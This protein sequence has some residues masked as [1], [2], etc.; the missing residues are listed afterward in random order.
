M[1]HTL[2]HGFFYCLVL[3]YRIFTL[4]LHLLYIMQTMI[5]KKALLQVCLQIIQ[6]TPLANNKTY[7]GIRT[8]QRHYLRAQ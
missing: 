4:T 6:I 7:Y 5:W 8:R 2:R 1:L 3:N